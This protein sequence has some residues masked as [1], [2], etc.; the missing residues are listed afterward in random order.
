MPFFQKQGQMSASE[1]IHVILSSLHLHYTVTLSSNLLW[2]LILNIGECHYEVGEQLLNLVQRKWINSIFIKRPNER[3]MRVEGMGILRS[4]L[5]AYS[6]FFFSSQSKAWRYPDLQ[7]QSRCRQ[8]R[9]PLQSPPG[10]RE[11]ICE[12]GLRGCQVTRAGLGEL[13]LVS[14]DFLDLQWVEGCCFQALPD[15]CTFCLD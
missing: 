7:D 10:T 11:L 8:L 14:A 12:M 6:F 1:F 13:Q 2:E 5:G 9:S 15:L 4:H 3:N